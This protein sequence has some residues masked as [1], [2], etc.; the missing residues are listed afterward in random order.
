M[1]SLNLT[2]DQIKHVAELL[3]GAAYA[4]GEY[5]GH[6]AEAIG[7]ALRKLVPDHELPVEVTGHL[8]RF[9]IDEFD[10]ATAVNAMGS[11]DN[12][13]KVGIVSLVSDITDADGVHDL[14]ESEYIHDVAQALG[15][16]E[17]HYDHHT[18]ELIEVATPPPIPGQ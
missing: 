5:D 15:I 11:L 18:I 16:D 12:D 10:I 9:D 7:D 13:T 4:D 3:M 1:S 6:E 17:K 2:I 14:A 8:A